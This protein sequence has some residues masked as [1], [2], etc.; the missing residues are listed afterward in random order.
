MSA[1][2]PKI[3]GITGGLGTGKSTFSRMLAHRLGAGCFSADHA[4]HEL[5]DHDAQIRKELVRIFGP[6]TYDPTGQ[7]RRGFLRAAAF[8]S[9]ETRA[10]LEAVIHPRV[11][12]RWVSEVQAGRASGVFLVVEIPLLFETRAESHFDRVFCVAT[13]PGVQKERIRKNG[14]IPPGQAEKMIAS[15]W[16]LDHKCNLSHH[17]VWNDGS[18]DALSLQ[19]DFFLSLIVHDPTG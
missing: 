13:S 14:R 12:E 8:R 17:V 6:E 19:I 2:P 10:A 5:L 18:L 16:S 9:A 3:F 15:Q 7:C 4:V 1:D 11:R